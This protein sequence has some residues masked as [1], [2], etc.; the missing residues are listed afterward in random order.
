[1]YIQ[2]PQYALQNL[3]T[4][5]CKHIHLKQVDRDG[6][7]IMEQYDVHVAFSSIPLEDIHIRCRISTHFTE[8]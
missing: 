5:Q 2:N 8:F 3:K 1:M 7:P 4:I 6:E